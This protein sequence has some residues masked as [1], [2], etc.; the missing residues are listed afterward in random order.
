MLLSRAGQHGH[1]TLLVSTAAQVLMAALIG[2][3]PAAGAATTP[4]S[5]L[6]SPFPQNAA[7][8]PSTAEC[9][10]SSPDD[11]TTEPRFQTGRVPW[12]FDAPDLRRRRRRTEARGAAVIG[13]TVFGFPVR[14]LKDI[15]ARGLLGPGDLQPVRDLPPQ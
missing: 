1:R 14:S 13:D 4:R 2:L 10:C 3:P 7:P 5:P 11:S 8:R 15:P 6:P 9:F 12:R